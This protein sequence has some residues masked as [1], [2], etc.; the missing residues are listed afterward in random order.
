L[1]II[2]R[3]FG[4]EALTALGVAFQGATDYHTKVPQLA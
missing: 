4:D 3:P 1:Q 2:G